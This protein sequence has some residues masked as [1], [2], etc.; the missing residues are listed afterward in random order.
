MVDIDREKKTLCLE[1]RPHGK[2]GGGAGEF[3]V[4]V[5]REGLVNIKIVVGRKADAITE[6]V[7]Y[8][9]VVLTGFGAVVCRPA[10]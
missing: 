8:C 1:R 10:Q 9:D 7:H 4:F 6:G 5:Y 3:L 2:R